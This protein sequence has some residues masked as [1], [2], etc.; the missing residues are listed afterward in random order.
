MQRIVVG[1]RLVSTLGTQ[2]RIRALARL[3]WSQNDLAQ[4]LGIPVS[5]FTK[6]MGYTECRREL[7]DQVTALYRE[8]LDKPG[9]N[10]WARANAE[11]Q[12]WP[13]PMEWDDPDD[14]AEQPVSGVVVAR[15]H[16]EA[17]AFERAL[18]QE[19]AAARKNESRR[20]ARRMVRQADRMTVAAM[21]S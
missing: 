16:A 21:A 9:R 17:L 10:H 5:R 19:V 2:R 1:P 18:R 13:S 8:L 4:R 12:G 14:P 6:V 11:R 20:N 7:A 3:G 15:D